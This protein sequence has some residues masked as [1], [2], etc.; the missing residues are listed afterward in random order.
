MQVLKDP[1]FRSRA[2]DIQTEIARMPAADD[3]VQIR[4]RLW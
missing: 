1:S 3:V 2:A 4:R